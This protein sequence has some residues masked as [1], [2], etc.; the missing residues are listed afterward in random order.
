MKTMIN[1]TQD[2]WLPNLPH[3][4]PGPSVFEA[5]VLSSVWISYK[6]RLIF[7]W[8]TIKSNP[9]NSFQYEHQFWSKLY[10]NLLSSLDIKQTD[11]TQPPPH[12]FILCFVQ[13]TH[14]NGFLLTV[15]YFQLAESTT[16]LLLWIIVLYLFL[17]VTCFQNKSIS[18]IS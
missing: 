4:Y 9:C 8:H 2:G 14:K 5:G 10:Q 7:D 17:K 3:L 13:Q 11:K 12:A 18:S 6:V 16:C 15:I 1:I